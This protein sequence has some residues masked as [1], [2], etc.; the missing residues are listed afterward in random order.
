MGVEERERLHCC[1]IDLCVVALRQTCLRGAAIVEMCYGLMYPMLFNACPPKD[2]GGPGG[3]QR[4]KA[5]AMPLASQAS[6]VQSAVTC[7]TTSHHTHFPHHHVRRRGI[8]VVSA[9]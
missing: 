3:E 6:E 9:L 2:V 7:I 1:C 8:I 4:N 5:R